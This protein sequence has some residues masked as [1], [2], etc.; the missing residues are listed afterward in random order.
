LPSGSV[1]ADA[2][3]RGISIEAPCVQVPDVGS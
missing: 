1:V 2:P 3:S